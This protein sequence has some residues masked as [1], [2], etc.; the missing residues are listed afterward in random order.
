MERGNLGSSY[1]DLFGHQNDYLGPLLQSQKQYDYYGNLVSGLGYAGNFLTNPVFPTSPGGPGSPL[2]HVDRSMRFQS[3]MRNFG[4]SY[5][6]WN[7][8]FG[9]KMNAN[10]VPSLLEEFKSNKSRSYELCE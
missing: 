1:M 6:S 3:S 9:G 2:R 5:G 7:S 8:D 4:G 10:L